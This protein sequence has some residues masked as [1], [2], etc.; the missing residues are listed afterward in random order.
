MVVVYGCISIDVHEIVLCGQLAV[1]VSCFDTDVGVVGKA[2]GSTLDYGKDFSACFVQSLFKNFQNLFLQFVY[3]LEE[4][5]AVLNLCLWDALFDFCNLLA[6]GGRLFCNLLADFLNTV[7]KFVIAERLNLWICIQ[8]SLH[9][10]T[11]GF[12]V[13]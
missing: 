2:L 6:Q 7:T 11:I 1:E 3:L 9:Q 4:G 5:S 12:Q 8:Y 10:W 13:A